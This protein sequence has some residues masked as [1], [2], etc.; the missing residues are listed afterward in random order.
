MKDLQLHSKG[1]AQA[2]VCRANDKERS[3]PLSGDE[4]EGLE[5]YKFLTPCAEIKKANLYRVCRGQ[6][7]TSFSN[8]AAIEV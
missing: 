2:H 5:N 7:R 1:G 3:S 6:F 8:V 4:S